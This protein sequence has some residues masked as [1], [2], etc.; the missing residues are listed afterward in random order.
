MDNS[1]RNWNVSLVRAFIYERGY[2]V[3]SA[4]V[5]RLLAEESN[6]P[7]KVRGHS[8]KLLTDI[9]AL[10]SRTHFHHF[11]PS[12]S[13]FLKCWYRT[14]CMNLTSAYGRLFLCTLSVFWSH[15]VTVQSKSSIDDIGRFQP[16][17]GPLFAAPLE[18]RQE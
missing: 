13:I 17:E 6:M 7:T 8:F 18:M 12:V 14:L 5:E 2:G 16:L 15:T 11:L 4:A 10:H 3:R 1:H 9:E